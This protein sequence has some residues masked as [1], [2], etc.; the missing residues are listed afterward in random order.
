MMSKIISK[1]HNAY[2][3]ETKPAKQQKSETLGEYRCGIGQKPTEGQVRKSF[4]NFR[5]PELG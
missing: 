3:L 5:V 4:Y 1:L 2:V